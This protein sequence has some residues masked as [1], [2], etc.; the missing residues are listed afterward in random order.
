MN[1]R[2]GSA[3]GAWAFEHGIDQDGG[4]FAAVLGPA[5]TMSGVLVGQ[6]P[7]IV[8]RLAAI[9]HG[10]EQRIGIFRI[11]V[12]VDRDDPLTGETMQRAGAVERAPDLGLRRAALELNPDHRIEAG[13][14]LVHGHARNSPDPQLALEMM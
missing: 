5:R 10:P 6:E 7:E 14:R 1:S 4:G 13:Q 12:L 9:G 3:T 11:D 2:F 8:L